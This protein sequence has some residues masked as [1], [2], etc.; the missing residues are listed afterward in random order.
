MERVFRRPEHFPGDMLSRVLLALCV[1]L[2]VALPVASA[3]PPST[4]GQA[5]QT[6]PEAPATENTTFSLHLQ[7]NGDA[8]WRVIDTYALEDANDSRAFETLAADFTAGETDLGWEQ[9]FRDAS[10]EASAATGREMNITDVSRDSETTD[11]R[12]RLVL[13]FTWTNFAT[14]NGSQLEI[15]DAFNTTEGTWLPRLYAN[16]TLVISPPDGYAVTS[17]PPTEVNDG[18][19]VFRGPQT[20]EPGYLSVA[21]TGQTETPTP[22]PTNTSD[23]PLWVVVLILLGGLAAALLYL[24]QR[25]DLPSVG[26]G[27]STDDGDGPDG[28]PAATET[29]DDGLDVELLSDEERVERLLGQNGGRM[30]QARIVKETG[31][32]NAKVS[33]LLSAMDEEGRIDKLRIGRENLISFPDEDV[34][35]IED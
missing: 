27:E 7:P 8:H 19:I 31:W 10:G 18:A 3:A 34:T 23:V 21:Y 20:F 33:Q 14:R 22:G 29:G 12:G 16:Q 32:S 5:A 2:F 1:L 13:E 25:D 30:K 26:D 28:P 24:A 35:E 11:R 6:T 9:S 15:Q 4:A 17:A